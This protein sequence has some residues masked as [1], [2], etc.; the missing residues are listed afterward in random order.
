MSEKKIFCARCSQEQ[1]CI[2]DPFNGKIWCAVCNECLGQD[3]AHGPVA[4]SGNEDIVFGEQPEAKVDKNPLVIDIGTKPEQFTN[5][6]LPV[7]ET[8]DVSSGPNFYESLED[9]Y[10]QTSRG[11]FLF[12]L[13]IFFLCTVISVVCIVYFLQILKHKK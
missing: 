6:D 1:E 10:T 7:E 3:D 2:V 5:E 8:S 12:F 4:K 11:P 13:V 9:A